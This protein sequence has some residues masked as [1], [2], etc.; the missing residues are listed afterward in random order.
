MQ[1][2][3]DKE[4]IMYDYIIDIIQREGYSPTVRDIQHALR[5]KSTST[6]HSYLAKLE[7]KGFIQK[8]SGKSRT[9]R[10]E[11]I[12]SEPQ[13]TVRVPILGRV[14]AGMPILAIENHDGYI[15]FP[16]M[17][18]N[19]QANQLYALRVRGESMIEAGILDGDY[20][21]VRK[22]ANAENGEIVVALVGDEATV[23]TFYREDGHFRLQ[24]ENSTMAPIIVNDVYILGRV[25][26]VMRLY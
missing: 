4:K 20:I 23:K 16:V 10:V 1:E 13:R 24:P 8:E 21:I 2:L 26:S 22:Q 25:V 19:F 9:L 18:R 7:K 6:V 15:D 5:I 12:V 17:N 3:K 11:S 14:A